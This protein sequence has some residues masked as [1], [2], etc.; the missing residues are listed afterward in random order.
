M[1]SFN[2]K[3]NS[4]RRGFSLVTLTLSLSVLVGML[5]LAFDL[6]RMYIVKNELQSF[7]DSS[8]LGSVIKLDGTRTGLQLAHSTAT[9]GPLGSTIPN[10]WHFDTLQVTGATDTYSTSLSG[11]YDSFTTSSI[12]S[13]NHY[14]FIKLGAS[15]SVPLYFLQVVPGLPSSQAVSASAIGGQSATMATF[16]SGGLAPF[17]PDAHN[18]ADTQNFG[19]TPNVQY[20]LKW[21]N[22]NSTTCTG[23]QG[24]NPGNAPSAHGFIDLGQG[25]GNSSLRSVIVYGGYP[26]ANSNPNH[27]SVGDT[28]EGVPGNRGASIFSATADRS[29][30]D[31]DQT[32]LTWEDYKASGTGNGRRIITVPIN[33]PALASGNGNNRTIEVIGFANFLLDSGSTIS[34]SSGPL[35]ATYIGPAA[36]NGWGSA[37]TDGTVVYR[38]LLFQ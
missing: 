10:G 13:S 35:C 23:D 1:R 14:R 2:I 3:R 12:A 15:V 31:P 27:V 36:A 33:N 16:T 9:A 19:L 32:S 29:S 37:G 22:G 28:I 4:G 6:G 24:F 34:G 30:Q 5:G 20:T 17:S 18:P 25:N 38:N 7:V 8:A 21:G 26:N 11:T